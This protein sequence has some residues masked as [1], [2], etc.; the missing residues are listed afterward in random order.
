[1]TQKRTIKEEPNQPVFSRS[2]SGSLPAFF[3]RGSDQ[4]THLYH[5]GH[6]VVVSVPFRSKKRTKVIEK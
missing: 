1:M 4:R 5:P 6:V 3:L 2:S